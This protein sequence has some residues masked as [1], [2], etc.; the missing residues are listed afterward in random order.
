MRN[1]PCNRLDRLVRRAEFGHAFVL[2]RLAE[3]LSTARSALGRQLCPEQSQPA[4]DHEERGPISAAMA[5][6]TWR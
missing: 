1:N 5:D 4:E 2:G 6:Q 3:S